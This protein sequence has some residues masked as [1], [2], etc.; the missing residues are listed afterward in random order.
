MGSVVA[1][2]VADPFV[3]TGAVESESNLGIGKT[4]SELGVAKSDV[5]LSPPGL[6]EKVARDCDVFISFASPEAELVNLPYVVKLN[7]P[8]VVGTTGFSETQRAQ[9]E[10]IVK[11]VAAV[12]SPNFSVGA[13]YLSALTSKLSRLPT[14]Y[15]FSIVEAHHS[16][17]R[18]APS[19]TASLLADIVMEE[20]GY[21][22]VVHGR[23]G[24]APR[25]SREL[26]VLSIR[27]GGI[28]GRHEVLA[29][30]SYE[31]ISLEHMVFSRSAF[32]AGALLAASWVVGR[33]PGVY[34][35]QEVLGL[36]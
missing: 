28:P 14:S 19:G 1:S 2:E 31:T 4:L 17:K 16:N 5:V 10:S 21:N 7:K 11:K 15:D 36:E 34:R 22:K 9:L 26:E 27:G 33:K 32:A 25:S 24:L 13:N 18:D 30:G 23:S 35:M 12:I 20:R 8:V 3:I 6:V 29:L